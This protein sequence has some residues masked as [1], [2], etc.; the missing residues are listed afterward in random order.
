MLSIYRVQLNSFKTV[1]F[2]KEKSL[3]TSEGKLEFDETHKKSET[4][5][6]LDK[7]AIHRRLRLIP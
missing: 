5:I 3:R 2:K 6:E 7:L 4:R 1:F